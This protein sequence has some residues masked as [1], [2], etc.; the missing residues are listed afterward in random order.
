M[1]ARGGPVGASN[2]SDLFMSASA[3]RDDEPPRPS[4]RIEEKLESS[5]DLVQE[6]YGVSSADDDPLQ[7]E[8]IL[9]YAGDYRRTLISIPGSEGLFIKRYRYDSST[10]LFHN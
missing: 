4:A 8:H 10:L 3:R 1:S 7:L 6:E 9:G 5:R 2:R